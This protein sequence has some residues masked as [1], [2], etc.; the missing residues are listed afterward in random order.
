MDFAV[1]R[2]DFVSGAF[3][4]DG[5]NHEGDVLHHDR[6]ILQ[7]GRLRGDDG[8]VA[9]ASNGIFIY[10]RH[11]E[12]VRRD[13]FDKTVVPF[14]H[15]DDAV[16]AFRTRTDVTVC[17][18]GLCECKEAACGNRPAVVLQPDAVVPI[19]FHHRFQRRTAC[20]DAEH[21]RTCHQKCFHGRV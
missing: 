16:V 1:G 10:L 8:G 14:L 4:E 13:M 11:A 20:A 6:N 21:Q 19:A 2:R 5:M 15:G 9:L 12:L 18:V 7:K 3:H 17:P